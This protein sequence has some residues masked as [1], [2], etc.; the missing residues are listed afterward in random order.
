MTAQSAL[1]VHGATKAASP[2]SLPTCT[3]RTNILPLACIVRRHS[4]T[5][6]LRWCSGQRQQVRNHQSLPSVHCSTTGCLSSR[7][8]HPCMARN[9]VSSFHSGAR[10]AGRNLGSVQLAA[11][12]QDK[13]IRGIFLAFQCTGEL[14][15][16]GIIAVKGSIALFGMHAL[17]EVRALIWT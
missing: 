6:M 10:L 4:C 15:C 2:M 8:T 17:R 1:P 16:Q 7:C 11:Q 14:M 3:S 9:S 13:M 5:S 12:Q